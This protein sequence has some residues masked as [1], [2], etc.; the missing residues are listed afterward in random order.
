MDLGRASFSNVEMDSS[1][2]WSS[3]SS[4]RTYRNCQDICDADRED[5][6]NVDTWGGVCGCGWLISVG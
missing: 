6:V 5:F 4:R 1:S 2:S 3:G